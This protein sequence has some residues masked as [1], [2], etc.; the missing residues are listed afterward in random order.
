MM[1]LLSIKTMKLYMHNQ[2]A[3]SYFV[4]GPLHLSMA[5]LSEL[6]HPLSYARRL[7]IDHSKVGLIQLFN[8]LLKNL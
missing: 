4:Y 6:S 2:K 7:T 3:W 8:K 1:N 5:I